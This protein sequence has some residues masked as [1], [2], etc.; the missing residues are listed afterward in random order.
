[1]NDL[2]LKLN[3]R[4]TF[5]IDFRNSLTSV[6]V[7]DGLNVEE[8]LL[9]QNELRRGF[10]ECF[11][12][13]MLGVPINFK[14]LYKQTT[15]PDRFYGIFLLIDPVLGL[16]SKKYS[17]EGCGVLLFAKSNNKNLSKQ[18]FWTSNFI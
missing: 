4:D 12:T 9:S 2:K 11:A 14:R 10:E 13:R 18:L 8:H 17:V 16:A 7:V 1:M 6:V 15:E 5:I 3:I